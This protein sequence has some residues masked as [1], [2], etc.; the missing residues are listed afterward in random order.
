[1]KLSYEN[2]IQI[3]YNRYLTFDIRYNR[4]TTTENTYGL[5]KEILGPITSLSF[6]TVGTQ[7]FQINLLIP[8]FCENELMNDEEF[9]QFLKNKLN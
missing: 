8:T 1:M 3:K 6:K 5:I 4:I 9:K 7:P 2:C